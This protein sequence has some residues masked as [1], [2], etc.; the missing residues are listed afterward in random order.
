MSYVQVSNETQLV[1]EALIE[2]E[3]HEYIIGVLQDSKGMFL[4]LSLLQLILIDA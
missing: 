3:E 4:G 1:E 2:E